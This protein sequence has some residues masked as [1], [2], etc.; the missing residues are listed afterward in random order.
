MAGVQES[1]F[2]E[3]EF[4]RIQIYGEYGGH[5]W[6]GFILTLWEARLYAC[7]SRAEFGLALES[8]PAGARQ[9]LVN[10]KVDGCGTTNMEQGLKPD[11]FLRVSGAA[12]QSVTKLVRVE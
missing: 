12:K 1:S 2:E 3:R 5:A 6:R 8:I 4:V 9:C 7:D 11:G 10:R